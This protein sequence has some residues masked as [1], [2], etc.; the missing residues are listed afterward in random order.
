[1][2]SKPIGA[3]L[4]FVLVVA[5]AIGIFTVQRSGV[6]AYSVNK[7]MLDVSRTDT[8]LLLLRYNGFNT[9]ADA[10]TNGIY[11]LRLDGETNDVA[12]LRIR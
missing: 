1:M 4:A 10:L 12:V 6:N 2:T 5:L 11:R 8:N 7:R 3:A 9:G